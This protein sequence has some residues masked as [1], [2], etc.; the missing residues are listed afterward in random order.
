MHLQNFI[1]IRQ[2]VHK[3]LSINEISASIKNTVE[4]ERKILFNH[5]NI[6]LVNINAYTKFERNPQ[7][8]L[9][10]IEHKLIWRGSR[11]ITLLKID[12]KQRAL[13]TTWILYISMHI[14]NFIKIHPFLLKILRKNISLHQSR[15]ITLLFINKFSPFAI[16]N[17]Y[18]PISMS[19]Q[20]LK[21]IG[22]KLLKLRVRKWSADGRT[23]KMVWRV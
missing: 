1:K 18:S 21:K 20:S 17:H 9:Q 19:M 6:H 13:A 7:N 14:Q 15:A 4:N 22:Q 5:P 2:L 16:P 11:A 10:D 8:N 23:L 3:I 12:Q